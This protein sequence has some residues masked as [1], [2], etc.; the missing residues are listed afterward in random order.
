MPRVGQPLAL[1]TQLSDRDVTKFVECVVKDP[2]GTLLP[3]SPVV[4]SHESLGL[5]TDGSLVMPDEDFVTAQY[6]I[7]DNVGLTIFS[8]DHPTVEDTFEVTLPATELLDKMDILIALLEEIRDAGLD[9]IPPAVVG[10][11]EE[12]IEMIGL[13]EDDTEIDGEIGQATELVGVIKEQ[14]VT[15]IV[16]DSDELVG[17]IEEE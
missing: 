12:A 13:I 7:F 9:F 5:Y 4:L 15:G 17:I 6:K 2:S 16:D 14:E 10:V 8:Q 11:I 3:G 1:R